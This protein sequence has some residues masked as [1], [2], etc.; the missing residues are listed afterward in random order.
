MRIERRA[1][2][3]RLRVR[4]WDRDRG[5]ERYVYLYRLTAVAWGILDSLGDDEI[6]HHKNRHAFDDREENLQAFPPEDHPRDGRGF[7]R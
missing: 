6:I 4:V 7:C 2:D 3:D 1:S 5:K